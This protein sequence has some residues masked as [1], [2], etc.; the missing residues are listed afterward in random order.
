MGDLIFEEFNGPAVS[1]LRRA[2]AEAKQR[3]S[4]GWVTKIFYLE[5][6]RASEGTVKLLVPAV[7]VVVSTHQSAL[8]PRGYGP[9]MCD[10]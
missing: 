3:W 8:N 1:A 9:F 7:F 5:L 6:L 4:I 2:I 10:P